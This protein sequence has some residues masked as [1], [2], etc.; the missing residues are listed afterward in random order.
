MSSD[1]ADFELLSKELLVH[2]IVQPHHNLVDGGRVSSACL[3]PTAKDQQMLSVDRAD[4]ST[5]RESYE[6]FVGLGFEAVAVLSMPNSICHEHDV[7]ARWDP[8][9]GNE[10]HSFLDYRKCTKSGMRKTAKKLFKAVFPNQVD[11]SYHPSDE[12]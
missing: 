3:C 1:S 9:D 6:T 4:M 10:A 7:P 8:V 2:R 11:W 5:P 12:K